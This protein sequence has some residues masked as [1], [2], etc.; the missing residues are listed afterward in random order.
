MS[1]EAVASILGWSAAGVVVASLTIIKVYW[2]KRE[3][4]LHILPLAFS[5]AGILGFI[6]WRM[7]AVGD[8]FHRGAAV[9]PPTVLE[10]AFLI[11]CVA[12]TYVGL[13]GLALQRRY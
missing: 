6:A 12:L 1:Y 10:L 9:P 2:F 4:M 3:Q 5:H 13:I 8:S 7:A 11:F